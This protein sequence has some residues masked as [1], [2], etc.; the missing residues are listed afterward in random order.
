M[1]TWSLVPASFLSLTAE[2]SEVRPN[3]WKCFSP[4]WGSSGFLLKCRLLSSTPNLNQWT[5]QVTYI[6][7]EGIQ[8]NLC[9]GESL[10]YIHL[11]GPRL[12]K[13]STQGKARLCTETSCLPVLF[14]FCYTAAASVRTQTTSKNLQIMACPG[15][16]LMNA[17]VVN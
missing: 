3:P 6:A 8:F 1:E 16:L 15:I 4:A 12:S 10:Q 7:F 5:F 17:L 14:F 2:T 11:R 9:T 13:S